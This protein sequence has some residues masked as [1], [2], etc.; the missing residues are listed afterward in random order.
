MVEVMHL[1]P[2]PTTSCPSLAA[3]S[4]QCYCHFDPGESGL[5]NSCPRKN[6]TCTSSNACFYF[7]HQK[8]LPN[9][10]T[11]VI[12]EYGCLHT[13]SVVEVEDIPSNCTELNTPVALYQCCFTDLCNRKF[14][15]RL[16]SEMTDATTTPIPTS[17]E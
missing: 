3:C 7:R 1:P 10:T 8:R 15:S 12:A 4:L 9:G 6:S 17:G 5:I 16:T 14:T 13:S 11:T 2:P